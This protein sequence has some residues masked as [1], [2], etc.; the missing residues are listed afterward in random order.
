MRNGHF[1]NASQRLA[2]LNRR[3]LFAPRRFDFRFAG[4]GPAATFVERACARVV[5]MNPQHTAVAVLFAHVFDKRVVQLS[6]NAMPPMI[7]VQ[8]DGVELSGRFVVMNEV[9]RKAND[10]I[11]F[12][13]NEYVFNGICDAS[14]VGWYRVSNG[15][16]A[17]LLRM[18]HSWS[19]LP[20]NRMRFAGVV[21]WSQCKNIGSMTQEPGIGP[22][23][24]DDRSSMFFS[25]TDENLRAVA[26]SWPWP[27]NAPSSTH[28]LLTRSR[29]L[30]V[31]GHASYE[32]FTQAVFLGCQAVEDLIASLV[33]E[34]EQRTFGAKLQNP[35]VRELLTAH[36]M[37]W[38]S[39]FALRFRNRLAHNAPLY[40]PGM[41][42]R[43]LDAIHV[44]C[45]EISSSTPIPGDTSS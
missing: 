29:R 19:G 5:R 27:E 39:N 38:C 34:V 43:M 2:V 41:A 13:G 11:F 22:D 10:Y 21:G 44:M 9:G 28:E 23:G 3:H 16:H 12:F 25:T 40:N 1:E 33:P 30:F 17:P 7:R 8:V 26:I 42:E 24:S 37:E 20:P 14:G 15:C 35:R 4:F 45:V 6:T 31:G 32:S 18:R 36:Q